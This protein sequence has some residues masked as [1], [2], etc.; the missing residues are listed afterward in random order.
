VKE[1]EIF[2]NCEVNSVI[3]KTNNYNAHQGEKNIKKTMLCLKGLMVDNN[4][5]REAVKNYYNLTNSSDI[6]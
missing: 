6:Q 1:K 5:A 2:L 3:K 4:I